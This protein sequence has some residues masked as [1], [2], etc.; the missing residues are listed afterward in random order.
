[1]LSTGPHARADVAPSGA[2]LDRISTPGRPWELHSER[3]VPAGNTAD[4]GTREIDWGCHDGCVFGED[5]GGGAVEEEGC[6]VGGGVRSE[7]SGP[8]VGADALEGEGPGGDGG[9]GGCGAA[10]EG[11]GGGG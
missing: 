11:E 4:G 6:A 2:N 9:V 1:M 10:D 8:S 7:V 3:D 5:V